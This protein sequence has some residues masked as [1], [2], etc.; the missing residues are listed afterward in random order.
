MGNIKHIATAIDEAIESGLIP[1]TKPPKKVYALMHNLTPI[2]IYLNEEVAMY[3]AW[4]LNIN[5]N[6]HTVVT[7][8]FHADSMEEIL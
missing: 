7:I 4:M 1:Q 5:N 8:P 2:G 3:D 6:D